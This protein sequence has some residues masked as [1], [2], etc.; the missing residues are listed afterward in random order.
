MHYKYL[1]VRSDIRFAAAD[2]RLGQPEINIAFIPPVGTTQALARLLG[3][4]RAIRY[5]YEG[6]MVSAEDA[7]AMGL[8]DLIF[9]PEQLR[10][11]VKHYAEALAKKPG[12]A[13]AA[14][15]HTIT[16]GGVLSFEE[17]LKIEYE[18][19]VKLAGTRDFSEGI[20][21]FLDK[22]KPEWK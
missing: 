4:S 1:K 17:G 22:R 19:A 13:L 9:P 3:R 12:E 15:R 10:E 8:V 16:E 5:L 6:A 14:I 18:S 20:R 2:A 7:L 21:A 11:K